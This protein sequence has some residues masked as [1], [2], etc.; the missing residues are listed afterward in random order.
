[1]GLTDVVKESVWLK[2]LISEICLMCLLRSSCF[3]TSQNALVISKNPA[4][5]DKTKG[6]TMLEKL[7]KFAR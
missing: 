1:M 5:H 3:V 2:G 7:Y 6:S 4:F